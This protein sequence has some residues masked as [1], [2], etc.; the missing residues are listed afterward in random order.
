MIFLVS[1]FL[2]GTLEVWNNDFCTCFSLAVF[3]VYIALD[4]LYIKKVIIK[5]FEFLDP[6]DIVR[7]DFGTKF[8]YQDPKHEKSL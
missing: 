8:N 3:S 2:L 6:M 7:D 1:L 4:I 5:V